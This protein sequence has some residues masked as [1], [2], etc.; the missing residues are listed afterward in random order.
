MLEISTI[1]INIAYVGKLISMESMESPRNPRRRSSSFGLNRP[2]LQPSPEQAAIVELRRELGAIQ[3]QIQRLALQRELAHHDAEQERATEMEQLREATIVELER[4]RQSTRDELQSALSVVGEWIDQME[5]TGNDEV[6]HTP[7]RPR[8]ATWSNMERDMDDDDGL[9]PDHDHVDL[10]RAAVA[11]A[12]HVPMPDPN[13]TPPTPVDDLEEDVTK[14]TNSNRTTGMPSN[15]EDDT[16]N[17]PSLIAS[18]IP[19]LPPYL[20]PGWLSSPEDAARSREGVGG[21]NK[22]SRPLPPTLAASCP[23]TLSS[24][25]DAVRSREGAVRVTNRLHLA[26]VEDHFKPKAE[27]E[28]ARAEAAEA[29][30]ARTAAAAAAAAAAS[31]RSRTPPEEVGKVKRLSRQLAVTLS[32]ARVAA[33]LVSPR[34]VLPSPAVESTMAV[35]EMA[36]DGEQTWHEQASETRAVAAQAAAVNVATAGATVVAKAEAA[37]A[38]AVAAVLQA[39]IEQ[40]RSAQ[41]ASSARVAE[42]MEAA[43]NAEQRAAEAEAALQALRAEDHTSA[44]LSTCMQAKA[45]DH[46]SAV[47]STCMQAKAEDHTSRAGA[48]AVVA[49]APEKADASAAEVGAA[50]Q[51][52]LG[53]A[54]APAEMARAPAET[55]QAVAAKTTSRAEAEAARA[56]AEAPQA[57]AAVEDAEAQTARAQ[58]EAA[59]AEASALLSTCMQAKAEAQ[60]ARAQVESARVEAALASER[61]GHA[62]AVEQPSAMR[63]RSETAAQEHEVA[64]AVAVAVAQ[65][66]AVKAQQAA[67]EAAAAAAPRESALGELQ[68]AWAT[69]LDGT[70]QW[71]RPNPA[72]DLSAASTGSLT[73]MLLLPMALLRF[74]VMCAYMCVTSRFVTS[75]FGSRLSSFLPMERLQE[76]P[77]LLDVAWML[78]QIALPMRWRGTSATPVTMVPSRQPGRNIPVDVAVPSESVTAQADERSPLLILWMPG[79]SGSGVGEGLLC[80]FLAHRL[81]ATV[82]SAEY[83]TVPEHAFPACIEDCEDVARALLADPAYHGHRFLVAG[84]SAG[85][86]L[87]IQLAITLAHAGV[88]VDGHVAICPMVGP[89]GQYQCE[90][91]RWWHSLL[92]RNS[93]PWSW[94]HFLRD[95]PPHKWDWRVSALLASDE[96]LTRTCPGILVFHSFDTRLDEGA[97]YAERLAAVGRLHAACEI[98]SR[99]LRVGMHEILVT[100]AE[101]IES[102]LAWAQA[103]PQRRTEE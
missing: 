78:A 42:A 82:V 12:L 96:Q 18:G 47:L 20:P 1:E 41:L 5:V 44:V 35:T 39:A 87:A 69:S 64:L 81:H 33:R 92:P 57:K 2:R 79:N 10:V 74:F 11:M 34:P 89:F 56:Q 22:A 83:R 100:V 40:M 36:L 67:V 59:R 37:K 66:E 29:A 84:M 99:G 23:S 8:A 102:R 21:A 65:A 85:G 24:P 71:R 46:A 72:H 15:D 45:E 68:V 90:S 88:H 76:R 58:V 54:R 52:E 31:T 95:V 51:H 4:V 50:L 97:A 103:W 60:T 94:T 53:V 49:R 70:G 93:I 6:E 86:Y 26:V 17:A 98:T 32:P 55:A 7:S 101:R 75:H 91:K 62:A 61:K 48:A 27:A 73:K 14:E 30:E 13:G 38:E 9:S 16:T 63:E 3:S 80:R 77:L 43:F 25:Q 28:A 19:Y